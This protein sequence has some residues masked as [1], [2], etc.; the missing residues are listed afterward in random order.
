[1]VR[2][3][4]EIIAGVR[5]NPCNNDHLRTQPQKLSELQEAGFVEGDHAGPDRAMLLHHWIRSEFP[6][7]SYEEVDIMLMD[8]GNNEREVC[9]RLATR[10]DYLQGIRRIV[11][12]SS[13][14]FATSH[15]RPLSPPPLRHPVEGAVASVPT[16]SQE[17]HG[18]VDPTSIP[19][20]K[21]ETVSKTVL[22][23]PSKKK[24]KKRAPGGRLALDDAL[25][26]MHTDQKYEGWSEARVRAFQMIE[27]NPNSYYY[28]FNAP[29]EEQRKGPWTEEERRLFFDRLKQVGPNGQWGLFSIA[30]PGRVGYQ[31]SLLPLYQ[32]SRLKCSNYYRLLIESGQLHDPNYVLDEKGK[33]HFL[34]EKKN[35]DGRIEKTFRTHSPHKFGKTSTTTAVVVQRKQKH[36]HHTHKKK[37]PD[38][39]PSASF[40]MKLRS[41][42]RPGETTRVT[43]S[44][45]QPVVST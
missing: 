41:A 35:P 32:H 17:K 29:G 22:C 40:S 11:A 37:L 33:A 10:P 8:C 2:T 44:K 38:S 18:P 27:E 15:S 3:K 39:D 1:M 13:T 30:I 14:P 34:F 5:P 16:R 21:R 43:R 9:Q 6:D 25:K 19:A 45:Q 7:I 28:R 36:N 12:N 26:Q 4:Q 23:Q 24:C 31:I 42:S 20:T